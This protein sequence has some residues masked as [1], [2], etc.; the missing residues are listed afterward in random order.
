MPSLFQHYPTRPANNKCENAFIILSNAHDASS[1]LLDIFNTSRRN[2]NAR[3]TPTDE[4]QDLLRSML[5]FACAGLD[6][7]VKQL[8]SDVLS[9]VID[10]DDGASEMF[11]SY[12][13]RRIKKGQEIDHRLLADVLG[14]IKP[15]E[16]LIKSLIY[17]LT[18]QSLQS[19]EQLLRVGSFFNIPSN[20]ICRDTNK[21]IQI[22]QARNEMVHELDVDFSQPSRSRRLRT[23][24]RMIEFVNEIFNVAETF[25]RSVDS[26]L[27][28]S[29][30]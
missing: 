24:S 5:I 2:R 12:I 19:T 22:F 30:E 4:E 10:F 18:S 29:E 6:S 3:G 26:K 17:D 7:M 9:S 16:R 1:S 8:V 11:K 25:L 20:N 13:E 28:R 14:D 27:G 21:L 23:R 15:R